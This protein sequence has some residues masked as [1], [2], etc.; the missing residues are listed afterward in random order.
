M[1]LDKLRNPLLLVEEPV[2][3]WPA[4]SASDWLCNQKHDR[5]SPARSSLGHSPQ[6]MAS[7]KHPGRSRAEGNAAV[8]VVSSG[9]TPGLT[10]AHS[11]LT[12]ATRRIPTRRRPVFNAIS[13]LPMNR[14]WGV[15]TPSAEGN[16]TRR[17]CRRGAG[18]LGGRPPGF[19]VDAV[20]TGNPLAALTGRTRNTQT[21]TETP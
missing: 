20:P 9:C 21:K 17:E 14:A 1:G 18:R 13:E 19:S 11:D 5:A 6:G 16:G 7:S 2:H 10:A 3:A 15:T 8:S 4:E 12:S